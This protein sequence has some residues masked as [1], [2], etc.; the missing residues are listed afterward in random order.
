MA[1]NIDMTNNRANMAFMGSRADIWHRLGQAMTPGMTIEQWAA[2]AG[3]NWSA[4]KVPLWANVA[5]LSLKDSAG[6]PLRGIKLPQIA[7]VRSDNAAPLGIASDIYQPHQPAQVLEWFQRYIGVDDRFELDTAGSLKG[8][9]IIWAQARFNG[10]LKIAGE[11]HRARLLMTT[12]FDGTGSTINKATMTRV[13]CN[14]TL[15]AAVADRG[16]SVVR[17]RHNTRFDAGKVGRELARIAEGFEAYKGM[18]EAMAGTEMS[19]GDTS[20]FFKAVLDIPFDASESDI[21]GRKLNQFRALNGAY[22]QTLRE[23]T[24]PKTAWT[25]LNAVTRYVDHDRTTRGGASADEARVLSSSFGSGA[26]LKA[27]AVQLLMHTDG[28][29]S[30]QEIDAPDAPAGG[31]GSL[32]DQSL[33]AM[34]I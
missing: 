18:A 25:A 11:A 32:I 31:A 17:T 10:E 22:Q 21:S 28:S 1:H 2:A 12:T 6:Q 33:A 24:A 4:V 9:A 13:V 8:G 5:G 16:K 7:L 19:I 20:V 15:D 23:G 14:N 27:K 3:L 26:A 34:G 30:E 29:M